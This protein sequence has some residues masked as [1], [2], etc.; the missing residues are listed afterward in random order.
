MD[1]SL[2]R[3]GPTANASKTSL[4]SS[5]NKKANSGK[6]KCQWTYILLLLITIIVAFA[7]YF[8]HYHHNLMLVSLSSKNQPS[9]HTPPSPSSERLEETTYADIDSSYSEQPAVEI[10]QTRP[11]RKKEK[12]K[13]SSN[14]EKA[15]IPS[16]DKKSQKTTNNL[17]NSKNKIKPKDLKDQKT[18][19]QKDKP[20]SQ[21]LNPAQEKRMRNSRKQRK[22]QSDKLFN[23]EADWG[24]DGREKYIEVLPTKKIMIKKDRRVIFPN[25][26]LPIPSRPPGPPNTQPGQPRA[27][28]S[29]N[30]VL[31]QH[32]FLKIPS[33]A[34]GEVSLDEV[35]VT[36][37]AQTSCHAKPIFLTMAT[38]GDELYW[39]LVE[40]FVYSMVKFGLSQCAVVICVDDARCL[41]L[42]RAQYFPCYHYS[43]KGSG[44]VSVMEQ[45]A[46]V[47]LFYVPL[48]LTKGVDVFMLDLD[49]GFVH[50][51]NIMV[52]AFTET[53]IVDI[54]VQVSHPITPT[55]Y[56]PPLISSYISL[57]YGN[58]R[59]TIS[60]L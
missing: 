17:E 8:L 23:H 45:I 10:S 60:L 19:A 57:C 16:S 6:R 14:E 22:F 40:N 21:P 49:V 1:P 11:E 12:L 2:L 42:C 54:L 46:K 59:R 47:K 53:P 52:K 18:K 50:D 27:L 4:V 9:S 43:Q 25:L 31:Q 13:L 41:E 51:P 29:A 26:T 7:F 39:Q 37:Q 33:L 30:T 24:A 48:A 35:M 55:T 3:R 20:P 28:V 56:T 58:N 38:V 34:S 15:S 32:P 5:H 36:L 44:R